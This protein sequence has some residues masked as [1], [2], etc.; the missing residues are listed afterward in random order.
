MNQKINFK[1]I[2]G[3][4]TLLAV[5]LVISF[6]HTSCGPD[7]TPVKPTT[8]DT[9]GGGDGFKEEFILVDGVRYG[10]DQIKRRQLSS[11]NTRTEL[12]ISF[13]NQEYP[14]ILM[15]LQRS[16]D[17][18]TLVPRDY[19]PSNGGV[20]LPDF[21]RYEVKIWFAE[22]PSP[23]FC[24]NISYDDPATPHE[25]Y[26]LKKV[27]GKYV[28]EFGKVQIECV[29]SGQASRTVIEGYLIWEE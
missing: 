5:A 10:A 29:E 2:F 24:Q 17:G 9:T 11:S 4:F 3:G 27:N 6:T 8:T 19:T 20:Y 16:S 7:D 28:S 26:T 22:G 15:E 14:F 1:S 23:N 18:D 12:T 21:N 13:D 25:T